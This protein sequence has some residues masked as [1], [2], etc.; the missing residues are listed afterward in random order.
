MYYTSASI[1]FANQLL[2]A[3]YSYVDYIALES[4]HED[5]PI[6]A[7]RIHAGTATGRRAVVFVGGTHARELMNPNLLVDLTLRLL[8]SYQNGSDIV[9]GERTWPANWI[10]TYMEALDIIILPNANPDGREHVFSSDAMWR[11]NRSPLPATSC[12]GVDLNRN[13]DH[14]H[15]IRTYH[16]SWGT[17]TSSSQCSDLYFGPS[18]LSEPETRNVKQLLDDYDVDCL[19]DVHSYSELVI[20]P[21]GHAL[22]QTNDPSQ[23]FTLVDT[24]GWQELPTDAPDYKEYMPPKDLERFQKVGQ[25]AADAIHDVRGRTY[26]VE[27]GTDL[28]ETTGTTSDYAYSRHVADPDLR[29]TYGF[30]FETGPWVGNGQDSFQPA[31]PEAQNIIDEGMSGLIA[32][33]QQCT[34]AIHLIGWDLFGLSISKTLTAMRA[35]RDERLLTSD[36]GATWAEVLHRHQPELALRAGK[37]GAFR[38]A[39]GELIATVGELLERDEL[40]KKRMRRI[41]K[42][43]AELRSCDISNEL[44]GDLRR[45][46]MVAKRF[47]GLDLD[48]AI[49]LATEIAFDEP[50]AIARAGGRKR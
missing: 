27:F 18:A 9:L 29:K 3:A 1:E 15:G 12:V 10:K 19:V 36:A 7:L 32:I 23:R 2:A 50:Q 45:L 22:T 41:R 40:D 26:V 24:S 17:T 6:S 43:L 25:A 14:L 20:H 42:L 37:D 5:R 47:Q 34:C 30:T 28:Y 48:D 13:Y 16:P 11:K 31:F 33:L 21:W 38:H 8:T 46:E 49:S 35:V 44:A 4:S 39:A